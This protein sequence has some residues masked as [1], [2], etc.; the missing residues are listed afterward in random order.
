MHCLMHACI[1]KL[2]PYISPEQQEEVLLREKTVEIQK[3]KEV[4]INLEKLVEGTSLQGCLK[5]HEYHLYYD[6]SYFDSRNNTSQSIAYLDQE[7]SSVINGI[8]KLC[9]S[10][11]SQSNQYKSQPHLLLNK[12]DFI[13]KNNSIIKEKK[14][15][16]NF[17]VCV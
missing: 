2:G 7:F 11:L 15:S 8:Y 16:K 13:K 3:N 9:V 5:S 17:R 14:H 10:S 12:G 4:A 1:H 6:L